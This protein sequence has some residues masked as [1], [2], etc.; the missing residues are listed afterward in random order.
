[1]AL[2]PEGEALLAPVTIAFRED[3]RNPAHVSLSV[4][5]GRNEG[6]RGLAGHLVVRTNEWDELRTLLEKAPALRNALAI[7]SEAAEKQQLLLPLH[8]QRVIIAAF[9]R[10]CPQGCGCAFPEDP[11]GHECACDGPC[12]TVEWWWG[13]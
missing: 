11:D 4:F 13:R 8:Q 10:P 12:R 1:M 6:A 3:A 2:I 5:I 7:F 9:E